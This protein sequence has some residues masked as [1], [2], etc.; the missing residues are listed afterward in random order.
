VTTLPKRK[1][2]RKKAARRKQRRDNAVPVF[3]GKKLRE[4]RLAAGMTQSALG[5][6]VGIPQPDFPGIE[7]GSRDLRLSTAARLAKALNVALRDMLP[8]G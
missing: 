8:P 1:A 5:R 4:L 2:P 7:S 6:L 3:F